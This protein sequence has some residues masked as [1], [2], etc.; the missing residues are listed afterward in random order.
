MEHGAVA[1]GLYVDRRDENGLLALSFAGTAAMLAGVGAFAFVWESR[2]WHDHRGAAI[3]AE[4]VAGGLAAAVTFYPARWA[5]RRFRVRWWHVALA[6]AGMLWLV[7]AAPGAARY[8]FP[9]PMERFERELGGPG[10]CLNSSPYA[11]DRAF[12]RAA[13]VTYPG[14]G[15]MVVTPLERGVPPLVL[16]H[17][18]RGGLEHLAA[19]D[20]GSAEILRIHGC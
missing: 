14:P 9:D 13:Q 16:D 7:T 19:A 4:V 18:V 6:V 17:A 12:P 15:R 3:A 10:Q 5:L 8:V 2:L 20:A 1:R 11:S